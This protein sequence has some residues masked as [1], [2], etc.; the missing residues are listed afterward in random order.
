MG[1]VSLLAMIYLRLQM[2]VNHFKL[3]TKGDM[4]DGRPRKIWV[5]TEGPF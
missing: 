5:R 4:A 2:T 3:R 1:M